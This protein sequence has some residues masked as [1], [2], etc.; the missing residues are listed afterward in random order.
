MPPTRN[1]SDAIRAIMHETGMKRTDAN[2]EFKRRRSERPTALADD[3]AFP[4]PRR[5]HRF[6][7]PQLD[8]LPDAGEFLHLLREP[9]LT[10]LGGNKKVM[11]FV[12]ILDSQ[13][14]PA[15]KIV[16]TSG[17]THALDLTYENAPAALTEHDRQSIA[18]WA[19]HVTKAFDEGGLKY[20]IDSNAGSVPALKGRWT[21]VTDFGVFY[22]TGRPGPQRKTTEITIKGPVIPPEGD[23][24]T[25]YVTILSGKHADQ[26][27]WVP[28]GATSKD[29]WTEVRRRRGGL[30]FDK[31][32]GM[33]A[34]DAVTR[35]LES[36][37]PRDLALRELADLFADAYRHHLAGLPMKDAVVTTRHECVDWV[38]DAGPGTSIDLFDRTTFTYRSKADWPPTFVEAG[39]KPEMDHSHHGYAIVFIPRRKPSP[40][41]LRLRRGPRH[42]RLLAE[43]ARDALWLTFDGERSEYG[44]ISR[45]FGKT[46]ELTPKCSEN[47][48]EARECRATLVAAV[49]AW[50][51]FADLRQGVR[52][53]ALSYLHQ[54]ENGGKWPG[55]R[56][57][58]PLRQRTE[59]DEAVN[60]FL[61]LPVQAE[62]PS[63]SVGES[64]KRPYEITPDSARTFVPVPVFDGL[65]DRERTEVGGV[66]FDDN[67][68]LG[69]R[70]ESH[71]QLP[72]IREPG[73][74]APKGASRRGVLAAG[75]REYAR[76]L[77]ASWIE[78]YMV[79]RSIGLA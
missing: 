18:T 53:H 71:I 72:P 48:P 1:D 78:S 20:A 39:L 22:A 19:D 37:R 10:T 5:E 3:Q 59:D 41:A 36:Q 73:R 74:F 31:E 79:A 65:W 75:Q 46:F 61:P 24:D 45:D 4:S 66:V 26:G 35:D 76:F 77:F 54:T 34:P 2:R 29:H 13:A 9:R 47:T 28:K 68:P 64:K 32:S 16:W 50:I 38:A 25:S 49:A 6:A 7:F 69:V 17:K 55:A 30:W 12:L 21:G 56:Q 15:P 63:L 67:E 11:R 27:S 52:Q 58:M 60:L 14:S 42:V 40:A 33:P 62:S 23:A 51:D 57:G 70:V 43:V 8:H 44:A